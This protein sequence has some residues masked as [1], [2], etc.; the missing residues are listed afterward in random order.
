MNEIR[1]Y[2]GYFPFVGIS[3]EQKDRIAFAFGEKFFEIDISARTLEF[4]AVGRDEA[5]LVLNLFKQVAT[6][7][8]DAAG[9][10]RC[11]IDDE[12]TDPH[13]EF[14]TIKGGELLM[15]LGHIVREDVV[16]KWDFGG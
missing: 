12:S 16:T 4:E 14:F 2:S 6:V 11:E 10:L 3:D 5:R 15:R 1:S 7:V 13:F 9:E 8:K